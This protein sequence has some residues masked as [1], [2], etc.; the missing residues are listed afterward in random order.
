M[1]IRKT[2][3]VA[4]LFLCSTSLQ[5]PAQSQ[6]A[7]YLQYVEAAAE[8]GWAAYPEVIETWK[9]DVNPSVLWGYNSPSQP[10]YLADILGFLYQE[11]G[12]A[13]YAERAAQILS[14]YGDLRDAYPDDYADARAEYDDGIPALA[15]FFFLPPYS[16]AYQQI[17]ESGVLDAPTR[18]KIERELANSL[19][20]VFHFPEWGAHNRA[21]LRAEGLYYGYRALPDHP[22]ADRWRQMAET[23]A[24]DN[25]HQWEAEDAT[26]YHPI[27]LNALF[28]Y[29]AISDRGDLY[30][31]PLLRYYAEYFKQLFTPAHTM[32]DIGDAAWNPQPPAYIAAFEQFARQYQ[33]PE[34]KWIAEQMFDQFADRPGEPSVGA[35]SFLAQAYRWTD[36]T[37]TPQS[38]ASGSQE[39]LDDIVGKKVVFRSGW[40]PEDTYLLLNYR[41]EGAGGFATREFLRNTITVEEEKMHHGSSDGNS[42]A[43]LMDGGSVLLHDAG[44]RSGLPSG[45]YGAYRSDYYH[46][47]LVVRKNKRDRHQSVAAFVRNSGAHRPVRTQKIDFLPFEEVEMSRTRLTDDKIGYTWDRIVTYVKP[48]GFFIVVDAVEVDVEDYYTFTNFWH[49]QHLHAQGPHYYDT[50]ID[51]IESVVLPQDK[52]LLIQFLDNEAKADSFFVQDRHGQDEHAI[53]QTKASH[54]RVGDYEVFVT[55]LLPHDR[56]ADVASHLDK[57]RVLPTSRYPEAIG[58]EIDRGTVTSYLGLK[59]D[60]ESEVVRENIRPRYTWAAGRTQYGP[61]ET[62]A[63][64]LFAT[65]GTD[66]VRYAASQVLQVRH[67]D[68]VLMEAL[69]NTHGLQPDGSADRVGYV[70]WRFW[71]DTVARDE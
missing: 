9:A 14:E 54:Y 32:P 38:P 71:E 60:L 63:H 33:D 40:A 57:L 7:A 48:D 6:K 13:R 8:A 37:L 68:R 70:K 28:S 21:M 59:L 67:G 35:A 64:F 2:S 61:F 31:S 29:A 15:N 58:L 12:E 30:D 17:R 43:L 25:L 5:S 18:Q 3:L 65:V 20:F 41:D 69:P 4:L 27:W 36:D 62:D 47:R 46:N 34:L 52:R 11:T 22:H 42:I 45:P 23:L 10:I 66:S 49:A 50:S 39:V 24:Y 26:I 1:L 51:S 53:Y 44:Y 55:A 56:D 16:R 19:D